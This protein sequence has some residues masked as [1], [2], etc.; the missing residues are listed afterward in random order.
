M[1]GGTLDGTTLTDLTDDW[2]GQRRYRHYVDRPDAIGDDREAVLNTL[3]TSA[4]GYDN[5]ISAKDLAA[6]TTVSA[7]TVRDIVRELQEE[8]NVPVAS[9]GGYFVIETSA[10][11][12]RVLD[13]KRQEIE[14]RR[15]R[16]QSITAAFNG[17][18]R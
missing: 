13:A 10:E 16:M 14:T 5:R 6:H 8:F 3:L 11:L 17:G 1:S 7:S 2:E 18:G 12:E 4:R 15:Q 9:L